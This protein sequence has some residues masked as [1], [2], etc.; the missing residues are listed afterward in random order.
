MNILFNNIKKEMEREQS[1]EKP[2]KKV[3]SDVIQIKED[4][5]CIRDDLKEEIEKF[6]TWADEESKKEPMIIT[7]FMSQGQ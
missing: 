1:S 3:E 7:G 4:I 6:D 2:I 5:K